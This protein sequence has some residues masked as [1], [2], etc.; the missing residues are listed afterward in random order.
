[1]ETLIDNGILTLSD[2]EKKNSIKEPD[3]ANSLNFIGEEYK[4]YTISKDGVYG[5][6]MHNHKN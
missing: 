4:Q 1:M 3:A 6:K 2:D 5:L